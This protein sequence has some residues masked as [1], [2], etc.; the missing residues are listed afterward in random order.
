MATRAPRICTCGRVVASGTVCAC[1]RARKAEA[2]RKRPNANA[3]GYGSKWRAESAAFLKLNPT[4]VR[5]GAPSTVVNHKTPH[6]MSAA[7][8]APELATAQKLFWRRSNW[9]AVCAPCHNGPIQSAER[10]AL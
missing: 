5:C 8:T 2:D 10:T 9:E 7:R 1:Q 6:R 3:R 4:C